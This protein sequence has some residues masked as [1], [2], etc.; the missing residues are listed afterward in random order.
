MCTSLSPPH[1]FFY[2]V[3]SSLVTLLLIH[4]LILSLLLFLH[5]SFSSFIHVFPLSLS[6]SPKHK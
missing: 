3:Y 5:H 6:H 2:F 4:T 1:S